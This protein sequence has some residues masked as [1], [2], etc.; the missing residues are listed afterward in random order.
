MWLV[1]NFS[2]TGKIKAYFLKLGRTNEHSLF[3]FLL[4]NVQ[5]SRKEIIKYESPNTGKLTERP[6]EAQ[7]DPDYKNVTNRFS[8][9]IKMVESENVN[10]SW[11]ISSEH[12]VKPE[13]YLTAPAY[14]N[15]VV[16]DDVQPSVHLFPL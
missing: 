13:R 12:F 2:D 7:T 4:K 10:P 15:V 9:G 11:D 14:Q 16:V 6:F 1:K 3:E 8:F 5:L